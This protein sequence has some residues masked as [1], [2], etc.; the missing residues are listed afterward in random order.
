ME[1]EGAHTELEK[2][3]IR[4]RHWRDTPGVVSIIDANGFI[5]TRLPD[6]WVTQGGTYA[7]VKPRGLLPWLAHPATL[8]CLLALVREAWGDPD[9]TTLCRDDRWVVYTLV[10]DAKRGYTFIDDTEAGVLVWALDM[11][12]D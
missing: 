5:W 6:G 7:T 12:P 11:A 4:L 2:R 9:I 3:A 10:G 1:I 8:G